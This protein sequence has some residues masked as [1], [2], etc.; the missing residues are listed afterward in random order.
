MERDF[1]IIPFD[2]IEALDAAPHQAMVRAMRGGH[3]Y[4]P[5]GVVSLRPD[6]RFELIFGRRR[7]A[8]ARQAGMYQGVF[9]VVAPKSELDK[10]IVQIAENICRQ[11]NYASAY[12]SARALREAGLSEAEICKRTGLT[13]STLRK[14]MRLDNL[15]PE[16]LAQLDEGKIRPSLAFAL[17]RLQPDRQRAMLE[18]QAR[19]AAEGKSLTSRMVSMALDEQAGGG[20]SV[21]DLF[22]RLGLVNRQERL[23]LPFPTPEAGA[24]QIQADVT[25]EMIEEVKLPWEAIVQLAQDVRAGVEPPERL[26][27]FVLKV[28]AAMQPNTQENACAIM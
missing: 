5:L 25:E 1:R 2:Q 9:L 27:D 12:R 10:H 16:F 6:G 14:L 8:S 23:P 3:W 26:V 24:Q 11:P 13:K 22:R 19:L 4:G 7:L 18:Q 15:I 21:A 20:I 17:S 28:A